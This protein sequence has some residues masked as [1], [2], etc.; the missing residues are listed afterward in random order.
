MVID[1][2]AFVENTSLPEGFAFKEWGN[3]GKITTAPE[4]LSDY[5]RTNLVGIERTSDKSFIS[6]EITSL[7]PMKDSMRVDIEMFIEEI[8]KAMKK[9]S[10]H[11]APDAALIA[12]AEAAMETEHAILS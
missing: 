2:V 11:K 6:L 1:L 12:R 8:N 3:D 5:F 4:E 9:L 10:A 7:L